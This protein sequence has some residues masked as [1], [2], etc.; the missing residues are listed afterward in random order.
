[1]LLWS[2]VILRCS[3]VE[4]CPFWAGTSGPCCKTQFWTAKQQ[5]KFCGSTRTPTPEMA[6]PSNT[7]VPGPSFE[8]PCCTG[9]APKRAKPPGVWSGVFVQRSPGLWCSAVKWRAHEDRSSTGFSSVTHTQSYMQQFWVENSRAKHGQVSWTLFSAW[10]DQSS[11]V[12]R[13]PR[14]LAC[15]GC[16][17]CVPVRGTLDGQRVHAAKPQRPRQGSFIGTESTSCRHTTRSEA[18]ES[19][20]V[21]TRSG[22]RADPVASLCVPCCLWKTRRPPSS[23]LPSSRSQTHQPNPQEDPGANVGPENQTEGHGQGTG[24]QCRSPGKSSTIQFEK[25]STASIQTSDKTFGY[26][27]E[28]GVSGDGCRMVSPSRLLEITCTT[29]FPR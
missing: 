28:I 5:L 21:D 3:S 8:K 16:S 20:R 18:R 15:T 4:A 23:R 2:L 6:S 12:P 27:G 17:T 19:P 10:S 29:L 9:S 14:K 26:R 24:Q 22:A 25:F 7:G 13:G 1:M 11:P